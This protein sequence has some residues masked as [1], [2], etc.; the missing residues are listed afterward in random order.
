[1]YSKSAKIVLLYQTG[2]HV[3][4]ISQSDSTVWYNPHPLLVQLVLRQTP[5]PHPLLVQ[6]APRQNGRLHPSCT[7]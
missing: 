4:S 6:L 2:S 5:R 7:S 3:T 1:M